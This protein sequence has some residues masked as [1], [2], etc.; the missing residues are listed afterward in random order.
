[1]GQDRVM[2]ISEG[3]CQLFKVLSLISVL[4]HPRHVLRIS[5]NGVFLDHIV[6]GIWPLG[7]ETGNG[8]CEA[9]GYFWPSLCQPVLSHVAQDEEMNH[10]SLQLLLAAA[11]LSLAW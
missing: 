3:L 9:I 8:F 10:F 5:N 1:M 4:S 11:P 7:S 6:H 2:W